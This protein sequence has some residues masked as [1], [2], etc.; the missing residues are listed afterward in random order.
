[1]RELTVID[2]LEIAARGER[3]IRFIERDD[4]ERFSSYAQ[5][6]RN[7]LALLARWNA[8]GAVAGD[9]VVLHLES[10]QEFVAALWAC[11]LGKLIAV[12]LTAGS[13]PEHVRKLE[14][15]RARLR[16][17]WIATTRAQVAESFDGRV[18]DATIPDD[19]APLADMP[20]T[21]DPTSIALVQFSSGSTGTPKGVTVT[22]AALRRNAADM[23][24]HSECGP[25]D[26]LLSWMPLTHDMGLVG[27]HI[28]GIVANLEQILMPT[29]LFIRRPLLWMKKTSEHRAT[30]LYSPNFGYHYFLSAFR[31]DAADAWDLSSI[32]IIFN[33]AEPISAP[34][35]RRFA[36][37]L[38]PYGF[39]PHAILPGY[40]LAE[41]TLLVALT[42][43][44]EP[45]T[46]IRASREG[47]ARDEVVESDDADAIDLVV[48]GRPLAGIDVR[49]TGP[50]RIGRIEVR[51]PSI[52][53]GYY[54]DAAATAA[55]LHDGWLDTGDLGFFDDDGQL[56]ITGRARDLIFVNGANYYPHDLE[57]LVEGIAG[58]DLGEVVAAGVPRRDGT[59]EDLVFFVR[60]KGALAPFHAIADAVRRRVAAESGLVVDR[61][62]P[63]ARIPKTTSGKVRRRELAGECAAG[64]FDAIEEEL[65]NTREAR[66]ADRS[67]LPQLTAIASELLG[68]EVAVDVALA[69]QGMSSMQAAELARRVSQ[70]VEGDVP[71]SLAFD[72]PTLRAIANYISSGAA[73]ASGPVV[74]RRHHEPIAIVSAALRFPGGIVDLASFARA[75][76]NK[77]DAPGEVPAERW[78]VTQHRDARW[79][80]FLD[81]I[82]GFDHRFFAV[83]A[84]E[85]QAID[86]QQRLLLE[87]SWEALE[88]AGLV[89]AELAGSATGVFVGI[90]NVDYANRHLRSRDAKRVDAYALTGSAMSTAA[91]RISYVY[92]FQGPCLAVDTACSSS[93]VAVHLAAQSLRARECTVALAGGV[94]LILSPEV[95]AGFQR[96]NAMAADGKCKVFDESADGYVRGEGCALIVM[97]RLTDAQANGDPILAVLRGSAINQ[98]GASNGLTAP[99]G[100]AQEQV[101]R[102]ALA[103]ANAEPRDVGYVEAHGTGTPLGDPQEL[104]AL[105]NVYGG[106]DRALRVGSVK[107]NLGHLESAAGIAGLLKAVLA[108]RDGVIPANLHHT[109][110]TPHF[111]WRERALTVPTET[112][113]WT[114]EQ[115][116]A[117]VSSFGFSGT[118]AH[119]I[120]A[121]HT[122]PH[123]PSAMCDP[124][125]ILT[126]SAKSREALA[127][128]RDSW[129]E[130]LTT[131]T[132]DLADVIA[133]A[134]HKRTHHPYRLAV[135]GESREALLRELEVATLPD[136]PAQSRKAVFVFPG[137]GG[138][139]NGM[140]RALYANDVLFRVVIEECDAAFRAHV[141]WSLVDA[142]RDGFDCASGIDRVQ[143]AL[144]A[145]G[146]ALARMWRSRGVEPAAVVG[147]SMGEIAAA[148]L[149]GILS[150]EDAARIICRR[151]RIIRR[152]SGKGTMYS[153]ELSAEAARD[154]IRG[155]EDRVSIAV[156]NSRESTVLSGDEETLRA[157]TAQL[158]A[159]GI[160]CRRIQVD[161]ASHSPQ[162]DPLRDE[163]LDALRDLAPNAPTIEMESTVLGRVIAGDVLDARYWVRNLR[164][165]VLFAPAI[166][167]LIARGERLFIELSPHPV[168]TAA[169]NAHAF[170]SLRRDTDEQL[171]FARNV[172]AV[173]CV[174]DVN[175]NALVPPPRRIA[176]LP[177][178]A[179]QRERF[180]LDEAPRAAAGPSVITRASDGARIFETEISADDTPWLADHR[181]GDAI[182]F[183]AAAWIDLILTA[184]PESNA[185]RKLEFL[186]PL[187]LNEKRRVQLEITR[188][189]RVRAY[190]REGEGWR[191]YMQGYVSCA[192]T[193][194]AEAGAGSGAE[195]IG[196]FYESTSYGPAF[197]LLTHLTR[198]DHFAQARV[199]AGEFVPQL[200]AAFHPL[201]P[202][203]SRTFVPVSI[204]ELIIDRAAFGGELQVEVTFARERDE[205]RGDVKVANALIARGAILRAA[206]ER[207]TRSLM[208]EIA[209]RPIEP[210]GDAP[211]LVWV[212]ADLELR[213][214]AQRN[215]AVTI[216]YEAPANED[217]L[218]ATATLVRFL[219]TVARISWS[220][221]PRIVVITRGAHAIEN[222]ECNPIQAALAAVVRTFASEH[223]ELSPC[224]IDLPK[225]P[226]DIDWRAIP[227]T[228]EPLI[229]IRNGR[230]F[231]QRLIP[232]PEPAPAPAPGA[233]AFKACIDR[234]GVID[235]IVFKEQPKPQ[236][237]THVHVHACA[238]NFLNILSA[239]GAYPGYPNG[240]RTL[241]MEFSGVVAATGEEVVGIA[242]DALAT[243][244]IARAELLCAKPPSL[245]FE[246]AA[247][248]PVA[249]ATAA[250]S[251]RHLAQLRA[252][253][254]VLIHSAAGGVGLAAVA[255]AQS[256]GAEIFA[257]AG[258]EQKRELLRARGVKHVFDSHSTDFESIGAVDVV[259][260]SLTGDARCASLR[261]LAPGGRFVEIGKRWKEDDAANITAANGAFFVVDLDALANDRPVVLRELIASA[262]SDVANGTLPRL[263]VQMFPISETV[264]AF[265]RMA[266]GASIGKIVVLPREGTPRVEPALVRGDG[267]YVITGGTG[268]IGSAMKKRLLE[269][270]ARRVLTVARNAS[271]DIQG[272][273]ADERTIDAI[274][275]N[276]PLR[277]IIHCAGVLD[278]APLLQLDDERIARVFAPKAAARFFADLPLDFFVCVSSAAA[279]FAP[280]GQANYAAASAY[281]DALM[282]ERRRRGLSAT[283]IDLG[284]VA[285]IGLAASRGDRAR[286]DALQAIRPLTVD[287][288]VDLIEAAIL[289]NR[290]RVVGV[291][292][293]G[294]GAID[295]LVAEVAG[296]KACATRSD[297]ASEIVRM[298]DPDERVRAV[299]AHVV[300]NAA[301]VLRARPSEVD[302]DTPFKQLGIDSLMALQLKNRLRDSIGITIPVTTF[303]AHPTVADL[304]TFIL[305]QL[306]PDEPAAE[307]GNAFIDALSEEEAERLLLEKMR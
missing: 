253:E 140:G 180:W 149:A 270:G 302:R 115:R 208:Y 63:V 275:A 207:E 100:L 187:V 298:T 167:R 8:E 177:R 204:E 227:R 244:V 223:P 17:P 68:R 109:R 165:P 194:G 86:P 2:S 259:L 128:T 44:G 266:G 191:L 114:S 264:D 113:A 284:P 197:Q 91:G 55:A 240:F 137:Q 3:G 74:N 43:P 157:L 255:I 108:V 277:G 123:L 213:A 132:Q 92:G 70:L 192:P 40:G 90:S 59:R 111:A 283:T 46:T 26:R 10:S 95:H 215:T 198:G 242:E 71:V 19:G 238:L 212:T 28:L 176:T 135:A 184:A 41:A 154:A 260:N 254:R 144:F 9:E 218:Q 23:A 69:E 172:A 129:L 65:R 4:D 268:A 89:P 252:G 67:L 217:V 189:G 261:M 181:V 291:D 160:D 251:L 58:I 214:I 282:L 32:R 104:N 20:E 224:A 87:V 247:A 110:P 265:H 271:A 119:A 222:E 106:R 256:I 153:V 88:N 30:V 173:A 45:V 161:V 97:K 66:S 293:H 130:F 162:M 226:A 103:A 64:R 152:A 274:L 175:W 7:A 164:E 37:T 297:F 34:L 243:D 295:P 289:E 16:R 148:H 48:V 216:A 285:G 93:L 272:D 206:E 47:L 50:R 145:F 304:S 186:E 121:S 248:L 286:I 241:G 205:I 234:P 78:D 75:L 25:A 127:A 143:P 42:K 39:P 292:L 24:A 150:F 166:E 139:W 190:A 258:S 281:V 303:W 178:Y 158:S 27:F 62:I 72:Y 237:E 29:S 203:E 287:D 125:S 159:R 99:N 84:V 101:I 174:A 210:A 73:P 220:P 299:E 102:A 182:V 53:R 300:A 249:Y 14:N 38:A 122:M 138:Q 124:P 232:A 195:L 83:S 141:D 35:C 307:T 52:T 273:I 262:L 61:V 131:D 96:L 196:T 276:A 202:R 250:W 278:D 49:I 290:T 13:S 133:T 225:H 209:W 301:A 134:T 156:I 11:F 76:A 94:N 246:D 219:Q 136:A 306:V 280:A 163:L 151:S 36:E 54:S 112:T 221:F 296:W 5:L 142:I 288:A 56:V 228:N 22:H 1:V 82:D 146:V 245:S 168:L 201:L 18:L 235:R 263:P 21:I 269:R 171:A 188:E 60:H 236:G 107:S 305:R 79:G 57:R 33:G 230:A 169:I 117:G 155:L 118:N 193:P 116:I 183:P 105:A 185:L 81:N 31:A 229:A 231:T 126:I 120:V 279:L 80:S 199:A 77:L 179:W 257:T 233:A 85:A 15:V 6:R 239:L 51:G 170:G 200:D 98:D 12:P 294:V 211:Q 267:T 147:H